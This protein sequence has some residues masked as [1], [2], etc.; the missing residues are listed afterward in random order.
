LVANPRAASRLLSR[1]LSGAL[2]QPLARSDLPAN[3]SEWEKMLRASSAHLAAPQL[4]WALREQGLFPALPADVA[5]YLDAIYTLNLDR[6]LECEN[7]LADF[8][9]LLNS[10][11]VRPVLLKGAAA[12][13]G[14]LY[15]TSGERMISDLDILIPAQRLPEILDK[16]AG[17]G[18]HA[19]VAEGMQMPDPVDFSEHHHYQPLLSPNWPAS[20]ELHLHPV[21]LE[22]GELL[23]SEEVFQDARL[24]KWCGG[25]CLLPSPTHFVTHN[26]IHTFLVN[27]KHHLQR[28]SLRQLF[29]FVLATRTYGDRIEWNDIRHRFDSHANGKA[30]RQYLA[31]ANT[32]LGFNVPN[33]INMDGRDRPRI[34]LYLFH[35][36]LE[37]RTALWTLNL[38]R[39]VRSRLQALRK[40][41][42]KTVRKLF[43]TGVYR[44]FI[45]SI[46]DTP[47][48]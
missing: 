23:T 14:G 17:A 21:L 31:L 43:T 25:E 38:A 3:Q 39:Q 16:V 46:L 1:C 7:Q 32:C 26:I 35:L 11:G 44:R 4:R 2:G 5:E 13:V 20:V 10:I 47:G 6:N 8:I 15:P 37:N 41:P 48:K 27:T 36:D 19:G 9:Q 33:S 18:Y 30:L 28:L 12:L 22:F 42:G 45:D 29:E 24:V 34:Q 40:R